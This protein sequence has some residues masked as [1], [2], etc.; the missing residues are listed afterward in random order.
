MEVDLR[1]GDDDLSVYKVLVEG[2]VL[3]LLVGGSDELMSLILEPLSDTKLVLGCTEERWDL[4]GVL[5]TC[6]KD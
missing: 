6:G 5:T 1:S 3:T 2:R 4:L